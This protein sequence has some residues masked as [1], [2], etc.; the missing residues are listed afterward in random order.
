MDDIEKYN[1][2]HK[3]VILGDENV[4]KS[5]LVKSLKHIDYSLMNNQP[6]DCIV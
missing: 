5:T 6:S 3:I 2:Y 4:G 1:D